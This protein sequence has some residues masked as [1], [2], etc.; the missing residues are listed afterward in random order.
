MTEVA[1]TG[2]FD[3]GINFNARDYFPNRNKK[4]KSCIWNSRDTN[5]HRLAFNDTRDCILDSSSELLY[6]APAGILL[7][8]KNFDTHRSLFP[9]LRDNLCM[10]KLQDLH[11]LLRKVK[12]KKKKKNRSSFTSKPSRWT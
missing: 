4:K 6:K 7:P 12:K 10:L 1:A 11:F 3:L 9:T 2:W 5:V 8:K